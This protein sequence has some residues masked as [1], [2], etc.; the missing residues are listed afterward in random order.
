[1]FMISELSTQCWISNTSVFCLEKNAFSSPQK[2][3][4]V[5]GSFFSVLVPDDISSFRVNMPFDVSL[6]KMLIRQQYC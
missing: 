2:I 1:M 4:A 5:G 6:V 3:L